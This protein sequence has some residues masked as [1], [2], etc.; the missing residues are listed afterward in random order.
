MFAYGAGDEDEDGGLSSTL[1]CQEVS[2]RSAV[3]LMLD[4]RLGSNSAISYFG[5]AYPS[6]HRDSFLL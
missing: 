3:V 5:A 4:V 1:P 2:Q 6:F